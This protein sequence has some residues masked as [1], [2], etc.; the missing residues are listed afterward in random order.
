MANRAPRSNTTFF[1]VALLVLTGAL[2]LTNKTKPSSTPT[3]ANSIVTAPATQADTATW[4]GD[5]ILVRGNS[6]IARTQAGTERTIYTAPSGATIVHITPLTGTTVY[7]E[8][9]TGSPKLFSLDVATGTVTARSD[10][11]TLSLV[12]PRPTTTGFVSVTFSNAERDFGSHVVLT[13]GSTDKVLYKTPDA[14]T[15]FAWR[16]DGDAVAIGTQTGVTIVAITG[17]TATPYA[18]G[19]PAKTLNWS[20]NILSVVTA[21]GSAVIIDPSATPAIQPVS[22]K[23]GAIG[24]DFIALGSNRYAWLRDSGSDSKVAITTEDLSKYDATLAPVEP[25]TADELLGV[26]NAK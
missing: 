2:L 13:E 19:A 9:S 12:A 7:I 6:I 18:L 11:S 10:I 15:D 3:T 26:L 24:R 20:A 23:L 1:L 5:L 22:A 16:A 17:G 14:I 8:Q 21:T 25:T 4:A